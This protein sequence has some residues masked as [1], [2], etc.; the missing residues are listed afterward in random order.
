MVRK[1]F[2]MMVVALGLAL[3]AAAQAELRDWG[4][5]VE[6]RKLSD[7]KLGRASAPTYRTFSEEKLYFGAF[8]YNAQ[9]DAASFWRNM[10][11]LSEA[12][13]VA[14]RDC[15]RLSEG[16]G[17]C[18]L[19][20]IT[21]PRGFPKGTIKGTGLS[22]DTARA[23]RGDYRRKASEASG[24]AAFAT[25]GIGDFGYAWGY[26]TRTAAVEAA[27]LECLSSMANTLADYAPE[28][29]RIVQ[30]RKLNECTIVDTRRN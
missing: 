20:A 12:V 22:Q 27:T 10:A 23:F 3:G 29:R 30:S 6:L 8:V 13:T 24:H 7:A 28:M 5:A 9:V 26:G 17:K 18:E 15:E 21:V 1:A 2:G 19:Y 16:R 11:S 4:N 14:T 25:S